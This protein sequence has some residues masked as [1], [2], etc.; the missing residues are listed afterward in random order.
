[1]KTILGIM[2]FVCALV[3]ASACVGQQDQGSAV[4]SRSFV[5]QPDSP[6]AALE[7]RLLQ[8]HEEITASSAPGDD[9]AGDGGEADSCPDPKD[10]VDCG[11]YGGQQCCASCICG[12]C[13]LVCI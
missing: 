7:S 5:A 10:L 13:D 4:A 6:A 12:V 8:E 1:M 2:L 3:F 11:D 9:G